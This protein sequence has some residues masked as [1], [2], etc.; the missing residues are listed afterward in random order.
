MTSIAYDSMAAWSNY[1][2][3]IGETTDTNNIPSMTIEQLGRVYANDLDGLPGLQRFAATGAILIE[4]LEALGRW[5]DSRTPSDPPLAAGLVG[6]GWSFS[7]LI[8]AEVSQLHCDGLSG[9]GTLDK[10]QWDRRCRVPV[11]KIALTSG[12]TRLRELVQWAERFDLTIATSGTHLGPT[13]AGGAA[14]ASHGSRIGLGGLQNL[15]LGMHLIVGEKK[16]VWIQRKTRPVLNEAGLKALNI[17]GAELQIVSDDQKFEDALVHLGGMGIVNGMAIALVE[18]ETFALMRRREKLTEEWLKDIAGGEFRKIA[19]R[20][21]CKSKPEF[22]EVTFNPHAPFDDDAT[23]MMYF[24]RTAS[25]LLPPGDANVLR[26]SDAIAQL[27]AWLAHYVSTLPKE[28]EWQDA[29]RQPLTDPDPTIVRTLKMLLKGHDSVFSFYREEG[30][31]EVNKGTFDP[32]APDI[33]GYY[34]SGLHSDEITGNIPGSLYNASFAIPLESLPEAIPVICQSVQDLEPSFV[35]SLRFVKEAAGTLAFTRFT[36]CAVIEID[37]LSPLICKLTS[38]KLPENTP[39]LEVIR[40]TLD[41]LSTTLPAGARAVRKALEAA[42]IKYSMHW[43]KL[44]EL[45]K[46]KVY[47]DFG[48][49][50]ES[51]S[52]IRRWRGTRSRLLPKLSQKLF[53]NEHLLDLGLLEAPSNYHTD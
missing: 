22:Y 4:H 42:N 3:T 24:K 35:F 34:W 13:I 29:A 19:K 25:S 33:D 48:N 17:G 14:T 51:D 37:G 28:Q 1:H 39:D 5:A 2:L 15:V 43:A 6:R 31:F 47:A 30:G 23:H 53:W 20:L 36:D 52:L 27:G 45:D 9:T 7:P 32:N 11:H 41:T 49:P 26:P 46:T 10:R 8:G 38:R 40:R 21:K 18:N 44:G 12:G 50:A 16:H